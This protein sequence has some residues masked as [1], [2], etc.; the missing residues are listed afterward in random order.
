MT[1]TN[2]QLS[3]NS[4]REVHWRLV[5][6]RCGG[7]LYLHRL[8]LCS[9]DDGPT[10]MRK[11]HEEYHAIVSKTPYTIWDK[12]PILWDPVIETATLSTNSSTD[13]EAQQRAPQIFVTRRKFQAELTAAFHDPDLLSSAP[14]F[15]K[16]NDRFSD[17]NHRRRA[18]KEVAMIGLRVNRVMMVLVLLLNVAVCL[19]TGI[20]AGVLTRRVDQGVAVTSAVAAIVACLQALLVL[21]TK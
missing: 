6:E 19:G 4:G 21:F 2:F 5:V 12:F 8:K 7:K 18:R 11:L 20:L 17:S 14:S 3:S 15:A 1:T 13:L 9:E 16:E 10:V